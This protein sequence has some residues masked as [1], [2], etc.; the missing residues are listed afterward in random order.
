MR[1]VHQ[2]TFPRPW[3][4]VL[5]TR[6]PCSAFQSCLF[7]CGVIHPVNEAIFDRRHSRSTSYKLAMRSSLIDISCAYHN[8]F[9]WGFRAHLSTFDFNIYKIITRVHELVHLLLRDMH[10]SIRCVA[11]V[12]CSE[13]HRILLR[14]QKQTQLSKQPLISSAQLS[15]HHHHTI[16]F[17]ISDL[18][19]SPVIFAMPN[20]RSHHH[21]ENIS[22]A[23]PPSPSYGGIL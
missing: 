15:L 17:R 19:R 6:F 23:P 2:K 13:I 20:L 3:H 7:V 12:I 11:I 16:P 14:T 10:S 22:E 18:E 8:P 5:L 9:S 1:K 21:T 4:G